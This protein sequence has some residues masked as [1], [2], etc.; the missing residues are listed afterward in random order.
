MEDEDTGNSPPDTDEAED[1]RQR[2]M[3]ESDTPE[4]VGGT[5]EMDEAFWE[6]DLPI[7]L[8]PSL[9]DSPDTAWAKD[10]TTSPGNH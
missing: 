7:Q 10:G 9:P 4:K 3:T 1:E 2:M 6:G 5:P 8:E